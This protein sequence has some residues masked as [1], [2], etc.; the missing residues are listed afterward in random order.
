MRFGIEDQ[1][2]QHLAVRSGIAVHGKVRLAIDRE[3]NAL[4]SLAG[5]QARDLPVVFWFSSKE[6]HGDPFVAG[7]NGVPA[8]ILAQLGARNIIT[9]DEEWPL[10]SWERIAAANPAIIV[11]A[12]MTRRRYPADDPTV[13]LDFLATDPVVGQLPAV[14]DKHVVLMDVQAMEPSIRAIDGIDR[15][16]ENGHAR[17]FHRVGKIERGLAAKLHD[18]AV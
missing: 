3:G 7:R 5:L 12:D 13:K 16:A 1:V 10:V 2:G 18:D 6:V 14:R 17:F 11:I 15:R 4:A 9:T 8:Y